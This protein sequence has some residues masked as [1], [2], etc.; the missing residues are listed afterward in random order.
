MTQASFVFQ[1]PPM[2]SDVFPLSRDVHGRH[3]PRDLGRL[4]SALISQTDP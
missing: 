3:E 2:V 1:L 4:Q